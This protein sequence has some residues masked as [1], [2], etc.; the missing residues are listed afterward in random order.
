MQE[1]EDSLRLIGFFS[2]TCFSKHQFAYSAYYND[3][4]W[5]T[6]ERYI[7]DQVQLDAQTWAIFGRVNVNKLINQSSSNDL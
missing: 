7:K 5:S 6:T 1:Y 3:E 2:F 4:L